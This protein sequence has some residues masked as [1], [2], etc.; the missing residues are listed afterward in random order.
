MID[1]EGDTHRQR[2][3]IFDEQAS[4]ECATATLTPP[5]PS[6]LPQHSTETCGSWLKA[7]DSCPTVLQLFDM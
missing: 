5:A 2:K 7:G 6:R 4:P 1:L 3:F